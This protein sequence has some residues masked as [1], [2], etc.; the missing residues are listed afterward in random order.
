MITTTEYSYS[1]KLLPSIIRSVVEASGRRQQQQQ[2][3]RWWGQQLSPSSPP[4]TT[5]S[6]STSTPPPP[7]PSTPLTK[8]TKLGGCFHR[9]S[10]IPARTRARCQL[11]AGGARTAG[12]GSQ[13][14]TG[15]VGGW[16]G[17]WTGTLPGRSLAA[18]SPHPLTGS[19]GLANLF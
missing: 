12:P 18:P 6:A 16:R 14:A 7:P 15:S 10:S 3:Q 13:V 1:K 4:T 11:C 9:A 2:Q 17:A 19:L 5:G 8:H